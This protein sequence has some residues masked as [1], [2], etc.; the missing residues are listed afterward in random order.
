MD[1][2]A[3]VGM[4]AVALHFLF[5]KIFIL[6]LSFSLALVLCHGSTRVRRT[7]TGKRLGMGGGIGLVMEELSGGGRGNGILWVWEVELIEQRWM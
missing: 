6:T 4:V 5:P 2:R 7:S 3:I 1:A